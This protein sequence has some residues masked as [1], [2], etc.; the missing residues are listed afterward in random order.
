MNELPPE[1]LT[2][3]EFIFRELESMRIGHI[4][5]LPGGGCMYLVDALARSKNLIPIPLLHEQSVGIAAEAYSQYSN[6]LSVALVTTGPGGTNALTPCA[7]AWT[8]STPV[9]FI[10]GQVK[11]TDISSNDGPR[12]LGF[13]EIPIAA[14]AAPI[15]KGAVTVRSSREAV[16]AFYNLI[17]LSTSGRPGPVWL[18]IP[19]DIQNSLVSES[20]LNPSLDINPHDFDD[21]EIDILKEKIFESLKHSSRPLLLLGNGIRLASALSE[22]RRFVETLEIP[23]LLTWKM[24]DF[25]DENHFL[26]AGRP[27]SVPQPWSNLVQQRA[28]L[29]L[30]LGARID[31]GQTAYNLEGFGSK[32]KRII[33]DIDSNE[34]SKF[35]NSTSYMKI[36]C[37]VK[38]LMLSLLKTASEMDGKEM[39]RD[40]RHE[41]LG[42]KSAHTKTFYRR[43]TPIKGVNVYNFL[44]TLSDLLGP[45]A[46]VVP[47]SSGAC[48]EI[49]MQAFRV[50]ERQRIFNSEG[51]GPMGFAIPA[52]LAAVLASGGRR[53]ISI[54]GDGGFFMNVQ[55]LA[56][57]KKH[58]DNIVF[59]VLN[60]N[61]YGSIKTTQDRYFESRRLGT[62]EESGLALIPLSSLSQTFNLVYERI[63]SEHQMSTIISR[64]VNG[65]GSY[66]VEVLVEEN[67]KTSPRV[68]SFR[69]EQGNPLPANMEEFA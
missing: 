21:T 14:M 2:V 50:K 1:S 29:I 33:V 4:F 34:L 15:T 47:G 64:A 26:N 36:N 6:K 67:Q 32:A 22:V 37:D 59:F 60:N 61:G 56:S 46:I 42:I 52:S 18:D 66:L 27:G 45:D 11:T 39:W 7:A 57:V 12:Q 3:A 23:A 38:Q 44:N 17:T 55:E 19:L 30:A 24:M 48:S 41:I 5:L 25:L 58:A 8:D 10:S 68:L 51:L 40:W 62:D 28:D 65:R 43:P 20:D 63:S 9:L 49:T 53:V 31:S 16:E 54:D 69:D 35:P 13:Q